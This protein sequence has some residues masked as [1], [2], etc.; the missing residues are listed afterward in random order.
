[1]ARLRPRLNH[2]TVVAY[3]ALFVALG[4]GA[5]A[6]TSL[7]GGNGEVHACVDSAGRLT[8]VK[9]GKGCGKHRTA[10]AWSVRAG[11]GAKGVEGTQGLQGPQGV[12]GA[13]GATGPAG[14]PGSPGDPGKEGAAGP[15]AQQFE[16]GMATKDNE[17]IASAD[18]VNVLGDCESIVSGQVGVEPPLSAERSGLY[19]VHGFH[20]FTTDLQSYEIDPQE[21]NMDFMARVNDTSKW[22]HFQV[23]G[24]RKSGFCLFSG[25]ITPST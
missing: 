13:A 4:G 6:A 19:W 10:I 15:G 25:V 24:Q 2:A 7:V 18:G 16:F 5:F 21:V 23:V 14:A 8:V 11:Q 3:L 20:E 22:V 1:M 9:P 17:V 12:A